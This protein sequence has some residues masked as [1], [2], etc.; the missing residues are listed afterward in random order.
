MVGFELVRDQ[1]TKAPFPPGLKMSRRLED[2]ALSRGLTVFSCTGC[3]DGVEGDMIL[4][5]PPL[6]ITKS[7]IDELVAILHD[8]VQVVEKEAEAL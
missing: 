2:E 4:M 7:Q 6:I 5:A 1:K 8:S 3:V